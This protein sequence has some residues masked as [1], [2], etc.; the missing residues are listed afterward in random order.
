MLLLLQK[1]NWKAEKKIFASFLLGTSKIFK[2]SFFMHFNFSSWCKKSIIKTNLSFFT[3]FWKRNLRDKVRSWVGIKKKKFLQSLNRDKKRE[4]Q[5][6][7]RQFKKAVFR[8]EYMGHECRAGN[9]SKEQESTGCQAFRSPVTGSGSARTWSDGWASVGAGQQDFRWAR[10]ILCS[11]A[12]T[13][14]IL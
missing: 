11:M 2:N 13:T 5:R 14:T 1:L 7:E 4:R 12:E 3:R 10:K 8:R 6:R 9:S